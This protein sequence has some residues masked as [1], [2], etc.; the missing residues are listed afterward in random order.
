MSVITESYTSGYKPCFGFWPY[1]DI[2]YFWREF[3]YIFISHVIAA[4]NQGASTQ[5]FL[6]N[7][8]YIHASERLQLFKI[9]WGVILILKE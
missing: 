4:I 3:F 9:V 6:Y 2:T 8:I 7:S 5:I 1:L